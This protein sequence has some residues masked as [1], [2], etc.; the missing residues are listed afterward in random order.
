MEHG[1]A[2][3]ALST[4][5]RLPRADQATGERRAPRP[6]PHPA[7]P[8]LVA[9]APH[10]VWTWD[11]TQ[12]PTIQRGPYRSRYVV[13]DR[14]RRYAL[15]GMVA[16]QE[17]STLAQYLMQEA[18]ARYAVAYGQLTRHQDRGAPMMA[19]TDLD[20]MAEFGVTGSHSRPRVSHDNPV[21]ESQFN[22][23]KYQPDYPG[24]FQDGGLARQWCEDYFHGDNHVHHHRGLASFTPEQVFTGRD[25]SIARTR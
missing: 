4:R 11:I 14:Y 5:H 12:L 7:I 6:A 15:A 23:L 1:Q 17:N 20:L 16:R 22:T 3:A 8:R 24:R 9:S 10:Q 19:R 2:P 21:S 18:I 25:H 13:L